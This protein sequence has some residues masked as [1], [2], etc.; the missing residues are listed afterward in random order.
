MYELPEGPLFDFFEHLQACFLEDLRAVEAES[1]KDSHREFRDWL[2]FRA[3]RGAKRIHT[4]SKG[5][6][7]WVPTTTLSLEGVVV[8]DPLSLL[9][10][11]SRKF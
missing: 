7:P 3:N 4:V 9:K 2:M 10:A 5:A 8:A 11:E 6:H 1:R